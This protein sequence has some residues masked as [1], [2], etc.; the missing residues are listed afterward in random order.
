MDS[1]RKRIFNAI[2]VFVSSLF[3]YP[4]SAQIN[5]EVSSGAII[6]LSSKGLVQVLDPSGNVV[7]ANLQP[8]AVL[9]DGFSIKTG[10]SGECAV[11]FS[12][13]TIAT[14]E[15]RSQMKVSTFLQKSFEPGEKKISD[16]QNEPSTSQLI[17]DIATGSLV[18]QTKKLDRSSSF[19]INTPSGTAGIRGTEFQLGL[20]PGGE[21]KLDVA[22]SVVSFTPEGGEPVVVSEGKGL[23]VSVNGTATERPIDP[24][25]SMNISAKN[26]SASTIAA[27]VPLSTVKQAKEKATALSAAT[28]GAADSNSKEDSG[29]EAEDSEDSDDSEEGGE[30][31]KDA[32]ESAIQQGA[33]NIRSISGAE[34]SEAFFYNFVQEI[35]EGLT[36][37]DVVVPDAPNE[38]PGSEPPSSDPTKDPAVSTG[39]IAV[40]LYN[41]VGDKVVLTY[42]DA[43]GN[44]VE[45]LL[46]QEKKSSYDLAIKSDYEFND[47]TKYFSG[48]DEFSESKKTMNALALMIFMRELSLDQ[49]KYTDLNNALTDSLSVAEKF[50]TQK[51]ISNNTSFSSEVVHADDLINQYERN[52]YLYEIGMMM[53]EYGAIGGTTDRD[54]A[55][56]IATN[57]L[58][59]I[60]GRDESKRK[61]PDSF[62]LGDMGT[63][64]ILLNSSI[65]N[66]HE[67]LIDSKDSPEKR[68]KMD[69]LY[70][71]NA[72]NIKAVVGSDITIGASSTKTDVEVGTW[73]SKATRFE[74]DSVADRNDKKVFAFAAAKDLNLAG[75]ILFR[76]NNHA[77]DHA[78]VLGAADDVN[79]EKGSSIF[80]EGTN[81]GIGSYDSLV[82]HE[83]EIDTGGNLAIGT[84]EELKIESSNFSVGRY[85]DRDN[86]YLYADQLLSVDSLAFSGGIREIYMEAIT[87]DLKNTSFPD[88]SEVMLRSRDGEINFNGSSIIGSVNFIQN[89][90]YGNTPVTEDHFQQKTN[91]NG[92][93]GYDSSITTTMG[94]PGIKIRS[95]PSK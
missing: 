9:A 85:S 2:V 57:I 77:E 53:A 1:S 56:N 11:L 27:Q 72:E 3:G 64:G 31:E 18:V 86:I 79:F 5:D 84:L 34:T 21:T 22:S 45:Y 83:I 20:S 23:D 75:E 65:L 50:L 12:N 33:L 70:R 62:S 15:P 73:L 44:E 8:G 16:L 88:Q 19:R 93:Y 13:G 78:L 60:G 66:G 46:N 10:F 25:V 35:A 24:V 49:Y 43:V 37:P 74:G 14:V 58:S 59:F 55:K 7:S 30:G 48:I 6:F 39:P 4:L 61:I 63:T 51:Y 32:R 40:V 90:Q 29:E 42:Q 52:P 82:L 95:F 69:E 92:H 41:V 94:V 68:A 54:T 80:N 38:T 91:T 47:L 28:E 87:V 89:V 17:L 67:D 36:P 71:I 81:L 76:N 26:T